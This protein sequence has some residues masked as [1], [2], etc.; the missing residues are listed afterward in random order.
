MMPTIRVDQEV[1]EGLQKLAEAFIDTPNTVIQKLLIEKGVIEG[2]KEKAAPTNKPSRAKRGNLTPQY[3][4]EEW[5]L[6]TLWAKFDGKAKKAEVTAETIKA[7]GNILKEVDFEPVTTGEPRAEN[8][9]AW[10]RNALKE[11]GLIKSDS[12]R[13]VWELTE[14][15]IEKA[16][17]L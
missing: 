13:G 5:L 12:P 2:S 11:R 15:G 10:A 9:I 3:F 4:Y 17:Q 6:K 1:F 8:T 14:Q 7:M 16:K